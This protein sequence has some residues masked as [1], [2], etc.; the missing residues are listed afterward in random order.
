MPYYNDDF[1][2]SPGYHHPPQRKD[3][4]YAADGGVISYVS[5]RYKNDRRDDLEITYLIGNIETILIEIRPINVANILV[6][7]VYR[8]DELDPLPS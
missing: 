3:R 5:E 6:C 8:P 1:V 2:K 4:I 7:T